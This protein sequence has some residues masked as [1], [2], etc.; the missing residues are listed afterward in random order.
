MKEPLR[1][2]AHSKIEALLDTRFYVSGGT[3][4]RDALS[5]VTRQA[6]SDLYDALG[7]GDLCYILTARQMG[8]SSLMVR[9]VVRLRSEGV[10]VVVLDLTLQG[11]HLTRE[12][13]YDGLLRHLGRQC[14]LEDEFDEWC[15]VNTALSPLQRLVAGLQQVVLPRLQGRIVIFIDEIDAVRSLPFP[16]DEFFATLRA[17]YNSQAEDKEVKRL[18]FCLIGVA[19]PSD[20]IQDTR[21]TPFNIGRRIELTDFTLMEAASLGEG[22]CHIIAEPASRL[23]IQ[24]VLD[25]I[26][27]WT[28]GHPYL[29]QR[30][31]ALVAEFPAPPDPGVV[32]RFCAENFLTSHA[33]DQEDNLIFVRERLLRSEV[34]RTE[35]LTLYARVVSGKRVPEN[36]AD[37]LIS[38]LLLSG[39]VKTFVGILQVRNRIYERV[40]DRNWIA[41]S[42][43]DADLQRQK[44]A[45]RRGQLRA[46]FVAAALIAVIGSLAIGAGLQAKRAERGEG[47]ARLATR[48]AG[49]KE[50]EAIAGAAE[51]KRFGNQAAHLAKERKTALDLMEAAR[52]RAQHERTVAEAARRSARDSAMSARAAAYAASLQR[53]V[54]TTQ[55]AVA[56]AEALAARRHAYVAGITLAWH[57]VNSPFDSITTLQNI[58]HVLD[59]LGPCIG[60]SD[61]RGF[62]WRYLNKLV[63][64]NVITVPAHKG[65]IWSV[66]F[67][68]DDKLLASA[69][70]DGVVRV[71]DGTSAAPIAKLPCGSERVLGVTFSPDGKV[72]ATCGG[73]R[74]VT[75]WQWNTRS[76]LNVLKGHTEDVNQVAF[77]PDG[78]T[79]ASASDDKSV[80]LWD[81]HTGK[82]LAV[83]AGYR[84]YI[85]TVAF[86]PDGK[87][88][89]FGCWDGT[90]HLWSVTSAVEAFSFPAH[91]SAVTAVTF[92]EN[93]SCLITSGRDN[94]ARKWLVGAT[95]AATHTLPMSRHTDQITSIAVSGK[96]TLTVSPD[97]RACL[98]SYPEGYRLGELLGYT[99]PLHAAALSHGGRIAALG[100]D[101]GALTL[102][103]LKASHEDIFLPPAA[104][105]TKFAAARFLRSGRLFAVTMILDGPLSE[106]GISIYDM[107][108]NRHLARLRIP[109]ESFPSAAISSDGMQVAIKDRPSSAVL[110]NVKTGR[111]VHLPNAAGEGF[112]RLAFS[113][114]GKLL[115]ACGTH[116]SVL[117]W[118]AAT[119]TELKPLTGGTVALRHVTFSEDGGLVAAVTDDG[120]ARVWVLKGKRSSRVFRGGTVGRNMCAFSP[121][122]RLLATSGD[123]NTLDVWDVQSGM[124]RIMQTGHSAPICGIAFSPDGRTFA[125]T[126]TEGAV[127]LWNTATLHEM[128]VLPLTIPAYM[129]TGS[130][131]LNIPN[132]ICSFS[133]DGRK[134]AVF[135][136]GIG[137]LYDTR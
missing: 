114:D 91:T 68:P 129:S 85:S 45:Y 112:Y 22:L 96:A 38:V 13:W 41:R 19:S 133:P 65:R 44:A 54:A 58:R 94:V 9:T 24:E 63:R 66:A 2:D 134:L 39:L 14:G 98:W 101:G 121:D 53:R 46:S 111:D 105:Q 82:P 36:Q 119:D 28:G 108:A 124:R 120:T 128:A 86:A 89:A 76:I 75:L 12:Q 135:T 23:Q 110:W 115:A 30:L 3:L 81:A 10:T 73:D 29:T 20:L 103:D 27:Y 123:D 132:G 50:R 61:M 55:S 31:C 71:W 78:G 126:G 116:G 26:L 32:D 52:D 122:G 6:D 60:Q 48:L 11:T 47:V 42:L 7:G 67:S 25:R 8:K 16:T 118:D 137:K 79:I 64:R 17:I 127:R 88:V 117:L 92:G 74:A 35:L 125:T 87:T 130:P 80:R 21:T 34:D 83:L 107:P 109:M 97:G 136:Y 99:G 49:E 90:V 4:P 77:S 51:A 131:Q 106:Q 57:K 70:D 95:G 15:L 102:W 33:R 93:A 62:E 72:L 84:D 37:P 113:P 43:P 18:T 40:F 59:D 104:G 56:R 5:Y 100:D 1:A 69:G